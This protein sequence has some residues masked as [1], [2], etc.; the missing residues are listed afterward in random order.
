MRGRGGAE[1]DVITGEDSGTGG[2]MVP[3]RRSRHCPSHAEQLEAKDGCRWQSGL[4]QSEETDGWIV[5]HTCITCLSGP[6]REMDGRTHNVMLGLSVQARYRQ[7]TYI[8]GNR[9]RHIHTYI[10]HKQCSK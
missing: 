4:V 5:T 1:S 10:H 7:G 3:V 6:V 8:T 9:A 2:D